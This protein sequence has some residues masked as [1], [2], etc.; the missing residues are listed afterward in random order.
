MATID[1]GGIGAMAVVRIGSDL[2][3]VH[4]GPSSDQKEWH[5]DWMLEIAYDTLDRVAS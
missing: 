1:Q 2:I 5:I 3:S 4:N